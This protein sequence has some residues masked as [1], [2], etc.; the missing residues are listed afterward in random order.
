MP[1]RPAPGGIPVIGRLT[2]L[3]FLGFVGLV[4][5]AGA[6]GLEVLAA[7]AYPAMLVFVSVGFSSC[8]AFAVLLVR[9]RRRLQGRAETFPEALDTAVLGR[10][11]DAMTAAVIVQAVCIALPLFS[12]KM[13]AGAAGALFFTIIASGVAF[14]VALGMLAARLGRSWPLWVGLTI[15]TPFGPFIAYFMM[16]KLVKEAMR[17]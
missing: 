13:T 4:L 2:P 10:L 1:D 11:T 3:E 5:A 9:V 12:D 16:R 17:R 8:V 15:I 14:L 7:P 6:S